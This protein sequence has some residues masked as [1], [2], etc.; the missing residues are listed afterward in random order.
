[1]VLALVLLSPGCWAHAATLRVASA[2]D[3]QT[4]DPHALNL[5]PTLTYQQLVYEALVRYNEKYEIEPALATRWTVLTPTQ[6]RFELRRGVTF[7]DGAPFTADDVL[8]SFKRAMTPPSNMTVY[9]GS[10]K[11]LRKVDDHTVDLILKSPNVVVLRELTDARIMN[12]A[13]AVKHGAAASQDFGARQ[14]SYAASHANGT[15]PYVLES[16][17]PDVGTRLKRNTRWWDQPRGNVDAIQFIPLK[18]AAARTNALLS[19]EIDLLLDTP[20]QDLERLRRDPKLKVVE[21]PEYRTIFIGLDQYR[22]EL[23]DSGVRGRNPLKD[24][25]VRQA[26]YQAIDM[27]AIEYRVMRG[28]GK[29]T[30]TLIAPMVNGWTPELGRRATS[31]DVP[32]ARR[33]LADAGYPEGFELTLDCPVDRYVNDEAL[34]KAVAAMWTRVGVRTRLQIN[35]FTLHAAK[36]RRHEG[37]A[38]LLGWGVSTFDALYT[39]EA[40]VSTPDPQGSG[41]GHYN[42]GRMGNARLDQLI[43]LIDDELNLERRNARIHEALQTVKAD[44]N[45]LPLHDQIR[46]WVMRKGVDTVHRADE[47]P[48]PTWTTI[49]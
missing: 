38:Y 14:E 4:F 27:A 25:R 29:P 10:V 5:A 18:S 2:H 26:L 6:W 20:A 13:W 9:V 21:G 44:Y 40:L 28:L 43:N 19:G 7:H 47:R 49:K 16:W 11:E 1:M 31:Y 17:Q 12:Q 39:L 24:R 8:F 41:R 33:L 30:G 34:C 22:D 3:I 36:V 15:G 48:M 42:G 37:S 35:P 32:T 23:A 46:P 45:Y